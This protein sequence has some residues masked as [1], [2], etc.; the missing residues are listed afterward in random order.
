MGVGEQLLCPS[1]RRGKQIRIMPEI[2]TANPPDLTTEIASERPLTTLQVAVPTGTTGVDRPRMHP[3]RANA[4]VMQL[5]EHV[6][7]TGERMSGMTETPVTRG[8][9]R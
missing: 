3:T 2:T 1:V 5:P 4:K 9:R 6:V 8:R 7:T